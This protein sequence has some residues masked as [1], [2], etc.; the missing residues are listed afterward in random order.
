MGKSALKLLLAQQENP[1]VPDYRAGLFSSPASVAKPRGARGNDPTTIH[2]EGESQERFPWRSENLIDRTTDK[3]PCHYTRESYTLDRDTRFPQNPRSTQK[4]TNVQISPREECLCHLFVSLSSVET[5]LYRKEAGERKK[6]AL[7]LSS[8]GPP[9]TYI[10]AI[11]I[12][13]P[14]RSL[15]G[16]ERML[17][18]NCDLPVNGKAKTL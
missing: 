11:F 15:Y 7:F 6:T 14:S 4:S 10:I 16:D 2:K 18:V 5:S 3:Q 9:R 13:I 12:A 17:E 8:H 1:L